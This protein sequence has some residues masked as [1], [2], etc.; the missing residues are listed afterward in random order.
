[1]IG[2]KITVDEG[3]IIKEIR[4]NNI[5]EKEVVQV[6]EKGDELT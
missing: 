5:R 2:R 4:R 6:L 3:D 1:M